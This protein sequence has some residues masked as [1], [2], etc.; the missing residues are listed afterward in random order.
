MGRHGMYENN[1]Q[2]IQMIEHCEMMPNFTQVS[3]LAYLEAKGF[4]I[5]R[6]T[7]QRL[8]ARLRGDTQSRLSYIAY[9]EFAAEH[10]RSID[11]VKNLIATMYAMACDENEKPHA[12]IR[13]AEVVDKLIKTKTELYDGNPIVAAIAE[14]LNKAKVQPRGN[15]NGEV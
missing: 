6:T 1:P 10:I 8:V 11:T 12:R 9:K 5:G 14:E 13:A 3:S 4:K 2:L 7:Y 15:V